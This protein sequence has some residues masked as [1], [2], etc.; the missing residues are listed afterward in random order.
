MFSKYASKSLSASYPWTK[1]E[2]STTIPE[3][4]HRKRPQKPDR[5]SYKRTIPYNHIK[6]PPPSRYVDLY[7]E[8]SSE[9]VHNPY[10]TEDKKCSS[11][12]VSQDTRKKK[13]NHGGST[14]NRN[15]RRKG[16]TSTIRHNINFRSIEIVDMTRPPSIQEMKNDNQLFYTYDPRGVPEEEVT[17]AHCKHCRCPTMY[18]AEKVF[19]DFAYKHV[20]MM[21]S[22][23]GFEEYEKECDICWEFMESYVTHIHSKMVWNGISLSNVDFD[24]DIVLPKCMKKGSMAKIIDDIKIWKH[25]DTDDTIEERPWLSDD[26]AHTITIPPNFS[27]ELLNYN[28][29][30]NRPLASERRKLR[31]LC[32]LQKADVSPM[33]VA[34]KKSMATKK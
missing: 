24:K 31:E 4:N 12:S 8:G 27:E 32:E 16:S 33:F 28:G 29:S 26:D 23:R 25:R 21:V 5:P 13:S 6:A 34:L 17:D 9:K 30:P 1:K 11:T 10:S 14:S 15:K 7:S 20:E 22:K 18:C 2:N 3:P 19:G